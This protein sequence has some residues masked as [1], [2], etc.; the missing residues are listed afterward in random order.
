MAANST[1]LCIHRDPAQL[2]LLKENGYELVTA[3][4]GREGLRLVKSRPVDAIV[5][6]YCLGLLDGTVV[7][8]EIKQVRPEVPIVMVTDHLEI[9]GSDLRSVDALVAKAD[10]PHFLLATLHFVL[11]ARA[12]ARRSNRARASSPED[13]FSAET[14]T[15]IRNGTVQF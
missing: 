3:A 7:A 1:L 12:R 5:L 11:N 13:P 2:S 6:E 9:P 8:D 10:G 4:N 14:W 15:N